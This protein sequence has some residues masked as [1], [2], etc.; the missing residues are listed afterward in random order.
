MLHLILKIVMWILIALLI[1][2]VAF[3]IY[4]MITSKEFREAN[5]EGW[6][7]SAREQERKKRMKTSHL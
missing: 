5:I 1:V 7:A 2:L 6:R 4:G 3:W